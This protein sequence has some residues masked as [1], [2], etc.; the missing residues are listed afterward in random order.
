MHL[1]EAGSGPLVV[2]LHGFPES[3]YSWR[4]QLTALA[5]AGFHAVAPD[6]RGYGSTDR[7]HGVEEYTLLHTV[8]DAVSLLDALEERTAVLVGHDWGGAVALE[9]RAA[10]ARQTP[11]C[12]R[13]GYPARAAPRHPAGRRS[14]RRRRGQPLHRLLPAARNSRRRTGPR[15]VRHHPA[16]PVGRLGRR[17]SLAPPPPRGRRTAGH[18]ARTRTAA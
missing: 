9:H 17:Q 2:L 1:A 11:R 8:G 13:S 12:G 15:P 10:Q 3:W 5:A 14:A 6:Q 18:L 16:S 7:P 4:H